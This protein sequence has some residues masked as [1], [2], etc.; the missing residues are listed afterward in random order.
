MGLK[1]YYSQQ[2][3]ST[4]DMVEYCISEIKPERLSIVPP[5]FSHPALD[6]LKVENLQS[7]LGEWPAL[8]VLFHLTEYEVNIA[9][10]EM[11]RFILNED[12]TV[13]LETDIDNLWDEVIDSNALLRSFKFIR[14][15]QIEL[16]SR[17]T[18]QMFINTK[19]TTW[20]EKNLSFV[21]NKTIQHT[22]AHGCKLYSKLLFWDHLWDLLQQ[23]N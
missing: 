18:D 20:G 2:L 8:R 16:L 11:K 21:I 7:V 5:H 14:T 19:I 17:C 4:E 23:E 10:P 12:F 6:P 9:Y 3:L 15:K 13:R 22:L 1:E